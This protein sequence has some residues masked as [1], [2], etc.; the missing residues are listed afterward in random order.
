MFST[1]SSDLRAAVRSARRQPAFTAVVVG[2]LA[3]G[4]GSTTAMFALVHAALLKPLPYDDPGRLVLARRTVDARVLMWNSAPDYYD[5]RAQTGA[6]QSLAAAGSGAIRVTIT[7]GDRPERVAATRVSHDLFRTL[8]VAPVMGRWFT[9]DEGKTG[10]PYVAMISERLARR[11][12]G[13]ADPPSG[14]ASRW[15]GP[16]PRTFP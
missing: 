1:L 10:A 5:Y 14:A 8:G 16:L 7:G 15:R 13:D 6:F 2:T 3:L 12:F 11:R 4:I 9:A